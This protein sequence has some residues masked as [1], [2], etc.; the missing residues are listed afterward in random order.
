MKGLAKR[1][2]TT[3]ETPVRVLH[4]KKVDQDS[5][6]LQHCQTAQRIA[7]RAIRTSRFLR[8]H[9]KCKITKNINKSFGPAGKRG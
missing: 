2:L 5:L 3:V 7:L 4:E 6:T 9:R 8:K 1:K